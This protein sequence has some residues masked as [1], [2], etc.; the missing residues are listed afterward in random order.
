MCGITGFW[1]TR[2]IPDGELGE[3]AARMADTLAHRGP[4]DA[5][6]WVD[7]RAGVALGFRRLAIVDLSPN[8][9]QPMRSASGR[10]TVVFKARC[11]TT[12]RCGRSWRGRGRPSAATATPR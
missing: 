11:T 12:A 4:D 5:G 6:Q 3:S 1:Q 9:H 10:Y 7:A 8:G 2:G